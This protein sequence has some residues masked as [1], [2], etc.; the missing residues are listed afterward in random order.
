M[1]RHLSIQKQGGGYMFN[2][3]NNMSCGTSKIWAWNLFWWKIEGCALLNGL[4]VYKPSD[5]H[6][7]G[8]AL[9]LGGFLFR[10]RY[11]KRTKKW[12]IQIGTF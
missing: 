3:I 1:P 7:A 4:N 10:V 12:H 11:S 8:F 5:K 2:N 9:K 6:S